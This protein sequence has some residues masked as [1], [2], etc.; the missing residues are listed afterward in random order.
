[1]WTKDKADWLNFPT[2]Q[3]TS[4]LWL[5]HNCSHRVWTWWKW[6][7]WI[8]SS[9]LPNIKRQKYEKLSLHGQLYRQQPQVFTHR[10]KISLS[11]F[12]EDKANLANRRGRERSSNHWMPQKWF[13]SILLCPEA[14]RP[15]AIWNPGFLQSKNLIFGNSQKIKS[16]N[17]WTWSN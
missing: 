3:A 6:H 4:L 11:L 17:S 14:T 16:E 9:H 12:M 10:M 7:G 13:S 1:M 15:S 2:C 8:S 5:Q